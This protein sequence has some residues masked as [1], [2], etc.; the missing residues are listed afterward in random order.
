ML[1]LGPEAAYD[2]FRAGMTEKGG[3]PTGVFRSANDGTA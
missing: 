3:L 1:V 2:P